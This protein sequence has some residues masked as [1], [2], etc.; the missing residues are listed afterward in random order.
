M[1]NNPHTDPWQ[2][3]TFILQA[4]KETNFFIQNVERY[5]KLKK[6]ADK[7]EETEARKTFVFKQRETE[8]QILARKRKL[9]SDH[10]EN[11]RK[12]LKGKELATKSDTPKRAAD[13][14]SFLMNLFSGGTQGSAK[15]DE[16]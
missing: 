15:K 7:G 3:L 16:S 5:Q 11:Q 14:K 6:K 12:K 1:Q 9:D 10:D 8:E 13:N 4:K 2:L